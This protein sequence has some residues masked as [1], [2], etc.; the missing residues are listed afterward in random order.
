MRRGKKNQSQGICE[1]NCKLLTIQ[2]QLKQEAMHARCGHP[3]GKLPRPLSSW[4]GR[5]GVKEEKEREREKHCEYFIVCCQ[6]CN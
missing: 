2:V 4:L 1:E 3:S 6:W 5:G